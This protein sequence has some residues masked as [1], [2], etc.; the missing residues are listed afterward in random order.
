MSDIN[1]TDLDDFDTAATAQAEKPKKDFLDAAATYANAPCRKCGGSGT[2]TGAYS[3]GPCYSCNGTGKSSRKIRTDAAGVAARRQRRERDAQRKAERQQERIDAMEKAVNEWKA[4]HER[5]WNWLVSTASRQD[6]FAGSVLT[7]LLQRGFLTERQIEAIQKNIAKAEDR[8]AE[9]RRAEAEGIT[10]P[11]CQRYLQAARESGLKY[12]KLR[13]VDG[14]GRRIVLSLAGG[15]SKHP[16]SVNITDG[17]SFEDNTWYGRIVDGV[18]TRSR[19]CTDSI[20][21]T[22]REID[23]DPSA[24]VKVQGQR[25]GQCCCCG[26]ELT[27]AE[28]IEAGIGPICAGRFGF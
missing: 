22:L 23:S 3:A 8:A 12:P 17:R 27:N 15:R 6:P 13:L 21:A 7:Q 18:F 24:A 2:W 16:G 25:T 10:L 28:S 1:W 4:E 14:E 11:N 5:E 26:R 9:Q 20:L 19:H